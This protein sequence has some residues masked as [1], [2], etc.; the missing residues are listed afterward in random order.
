[1][2]VY[3]PYTP[4]QVLGVAGV[5]QCQ[6]AI[7]NQNGYPMGTTGTIS[8]GQSRG[9]G[10]PTMIKSAAGQFPPPRTVNVTGSNGR[11]RLKFVFT[12][13]DIGEFD[14]QFGAFDLNFYT[15]SSGT[16]IR[17]L[18]DWQIVGMQTDA[19]PAAVQ[20]MLLFNIDAEEAGISTFGRK[21]WWN[22]F[23]PLANVYLQGAAHQ[24]AAEGGFTYRVSPV[25][26]GVLPW[27]VALSSG[28]DGYTEAAGFGV[29]SKNPLTL[30]TFISDGSTPNF[31][32]NY[33]PTEDQTGNAAFVFRNG[34]ATPISIT[35]LVVAT[36][37]LTMA[38]NGTA[39]D[40]NLAIYEAISADLLAA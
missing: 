32:L 22:L 29:T 5:A 1:M 23:I 27:A 24:E 14:M 34:S 21:A 36:K 18:G 40:V 39:G 37:A 31:T 19:A 7:V 28:V 33:R 25:Q 6:Y 9:M 8:N 15:N 10:V 16:K 20:V 11:K 17:T 13:A 12:A 2:A 35:S 4:I 26:A 3:D 38:S 30:D